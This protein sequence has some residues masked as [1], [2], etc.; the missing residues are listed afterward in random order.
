LSLRGPFFFLPSI[1]SATLSTGSFLLQSSS[2]SKINRGRHIAILSVAASAT[3]ALANIASGLIAG[4]TAVVAAGLEFAG[5]VLTSLIVFLGMVIASR[6]PDANHPYGHGRFEILAGLLV[7]LILVLGGCGIGFRA[8][9]KVGEVHAPPMR[10]AAYPLI[11]AILVKAVLATVKFRTGRGMGSAALVADAWNDAVDI[12]SAMVAL[13]GL[14][15]TL[16]NPVEFLAADHYGGFAVGV[17][18]ILT[19]LRVARDASME[20]TDTMPSD[21]VLEK[22]RRFALEVPGVQGVEKCFARKTGL[23]YH[24]DIHIEVDPAL[25]VATSHA[26]ATDVRQHLRHTVPTVAD[27]LVHIEPSYGGDRVIRHRHM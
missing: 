19:G 9:E 26:I 4:S 7:G 24:V 20:L 13:I 10:A 17:I 2:I 5:D 11:A 25:T 1:H 15:L 16:H 12:L 3:L 8:L 18:V 14:G 6:P 21:A 27:V 23:Q 22:I